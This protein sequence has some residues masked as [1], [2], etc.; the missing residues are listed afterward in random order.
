MFEGR[1]YHDQEDL[2]C[3]DTCI[4]VILVKMKDGQING[5]DFYKFNSKKTKFANP[6][7]RIVETL[8]VMQSVKLFCS[9]NL[10]RFN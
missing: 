8:E 3:T 2:Q 6:I 7:P 4:T 10:I 1:G 5:I 9:L